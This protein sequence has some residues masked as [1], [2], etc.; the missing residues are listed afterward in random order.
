MNEDTDN[1]KK[2]AGIEPA[3]FNIPAE[4]AMY[5]MLFAEILSRIERL[6][7][8]YSMIMIMLLQRILASFSR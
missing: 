6:L 2:D 1:M 4:V 3:S 8:G 5:K 7:D